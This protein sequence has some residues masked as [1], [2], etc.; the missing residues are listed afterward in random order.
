MAAPSLIHSLNFQQQKQQNVLVIVFDALSAYNISFYGYPRETMPN[1]AKWADRAVVYH[2]HYAGGNFTTPGTAS[3]LTGTLPWTHRAFDLYGRM[4]DAFIKRNIFSA[5]RNHYRIAYT[6][7]PVANTLLTQLDGEMDS[8]VPLSDLMLTND[9]VVTSILKNDESTASVAWS[10]ATKNKEE[11]FSYSLFLSHILGALRERTIKELRSQFPGGIPST[12]GDNYFLLEDAIDWLRNSLSNMSLPFFVYFH[13]MPPHGPY[14]THKNFFGFFDEDGYWPP[15]KSIDIFARE[16]GIAFEHLLRRRTNYDEFILYVDQEFGRLM[17]E[18]EMNGLLDNTWV[19]LTTD[20]GELFERGI[21]GHL[22]PVLYEP[23]IQIPLVIF[24][25]GRNTREDVYSSTSAVDVLP[26]LLHVTGQNQATWS[27]GAIL[28]PFST[29]DN[30]DRS[31]YVVQARKNP[32]YGPLTEATF[33][34][35]KDQYKLMYFIGYEELKDKE[36]VELY[37]LENDPEELNDLST[38]KRETTA[39]LLNELKRKLAQVNEPYL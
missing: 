5:F 33:A 24:E 32:M 3:L 31:V 27:D 2:K 29:S 18:M 19:V 20:H 30:S 35:V 6:H 39:E 23:V 12:S 34:L 15:F 11:G 9:E 37:N 17:D 7:N 22:T 14:N 8:H 36:R 25:P 4:D 28:P 16:Q 21:V 1:L 38:S 26:T 10:R 13:L